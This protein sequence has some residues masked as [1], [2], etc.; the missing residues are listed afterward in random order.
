M[1]SA[2]SHLLYS[3]ASPVF[4]FT[5]EATNAPSVGPCYSMAEAVLAQIY[6]VRMLSFLVPA[7][8]VAVLATG[9]VATKTRPRFVPMLLIFLGSLGVFVLL[10]L[11]NLLLG[12]DQYPYGPSRAWL[13][14]HYSD[15]NVVILIAS[16][17]VIVFGAYL[18]KLLLQKLTLNRVPTITVVVIVG[19]AVLAWL[20]YTP[21]LRG[22]LGLDP[23]IQSVGGCA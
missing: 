20:Y 2:I 11:P 23:L 7:A 21:Y 9:Y 4:A 3:L 17:G 16:G 10:A 15:W 8:I 12:L 18:L 14:E 19:I 13:L 22:S 6:Q 5:G 1:A